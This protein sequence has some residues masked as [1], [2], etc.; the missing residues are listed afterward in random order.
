MACGDWVYRQIANDKSQISAAAAPSKR[1]FGRWRGKG[2]AEESGYVY[3]LF[4]RWDKSGIIDGDKEVNAVFDRC[5]YTAG[6]FDGKDLSELKPV[7]IY[8]MIQMGLEQSYVEISDELS[9]SMGHDYTYDDVESYELITEKTVFDGTNYIE[10]DVCPMD[11]DRSFVFAI[12]YEFADGNN[13]EATLVHCFDAASGDGFQLNYTTN[14]MV[15]WG[16]NNSQVCAYKNAREML[17]IRHIAGETK[18]HVYTSNL[19]GNVINTF[20]LGRVRIMTTN[21]PIV[22][23]AK[24]MLDGTVKYNIP[25]E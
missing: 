17:V 14:P 4:N 16:S 2:T 11:I 13:L 21:F 18:L 10:T 7:E 15:Q 9:F 3:H 22:F 23:G 6:Y 5:A 19:S 8:A 20:D 25:E 12:D 1:V 24:K